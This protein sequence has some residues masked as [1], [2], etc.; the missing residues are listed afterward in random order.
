MDVQYRKIVAVSQVPDKVRQTGVIDADNAKRAYYRGVISTNQLDSYFSQMA[1]SSLKNFARDAEKGVTV[2]DSH[3]HRTAGIGMSATGMYEEG[4]VYSDFYLVRSVPLGA[5]QSYASTDGFIAMLEDGALRDI[6]VGFTG[7]TEYCDICGGNIWSY[8]DCR[9]WPGNSYIIGEGEEETIVVCTTTIEG[10]ELSEFSLVFDGATPGAEVVEK[11][12]YLAEQGLIDLKEK[13]NIEKR[14]DVRFK[15]G[16]NFPEPKELELKNTTDTIDLDNGKQPATRGKEGDTNMTLEEVQKE[17]EETKTQLNEARENAKTHKEA[18]ERAT[19]L[20]AEN[21]SLTT[22]NKTL[23]ER[24]DQ[25]R[26]TIERVLGE[27]RNAETDLD[28]LKPLA[29]EGKRARKEAEEES[30]KQY[31]RSQG[32]TLDDAKL[33]R[34]KGT[35]ANLDSVQDVRD[36]GE[37]Y[38]EIADDKYPEGRKTKDDTKSD[39]GGDDGDDK[40]IDPSVPGND[41][42]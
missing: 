29:D 35:L 19:T 37:T 15:Q 39:D 13:H 21:D 41:A 25:D 22:R 31:I 8:A 6:S 33:E 10:A 20:E 5:S 9:H 38:K 11:A 36:M 30:A 32:D 12:N 42:Y 40:T 7:G 34:F 1:E 28:K 17:L 24:Q 27:K 14:F 3:N 26:E 16:L 18:A 2:L 23:E 4:K